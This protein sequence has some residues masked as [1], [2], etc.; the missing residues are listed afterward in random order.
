MAI[1]I[2]RR[3]FVAALG[4]VAVAWPLTARAQQ[5]GMPRIGVLNG[6]S[7]SEYGHLIAAFREALRENGYVENQNIEIEYRWADGQYDKLPALAADLIANKVT[8]IFATGGIASA[9]AAKSV[10]ATIPIV[11]ANGSDPVKLGLVP[12]LNRPAGNATGIVFFALALE[13]KRVQLL[14]ELVPDV[15]TIGFLVNK[16]N[17]NADFQLSDVQA[18]VNSIGLKA[19]IFPAGSKN[20]ISLAF[21]TLVRQRIRALAILTDPV[22][23]SSLEQIAVLAKSHAVA[24]IASS[25]AFPTNG[26]LINYGPNVADAY[27]QAAGYVARIL[28][29]ASPADLP[30]Q[31]STKFE[32]VINITTAKALGLDVPPSLIAIAD[33]VIE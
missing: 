4:G 32:L 11:F 19:E 28:K 33:E 6:A 3:Q 9:I 30:V 29:G 7:Q 5:P 10:T 15:D 12:S 16:S 25:R 24:T 21:A 27:R 2:G 14:H 31:Q 23:Q 18:A 17:L 22:F 1:N 26:G 20:E 13:A 8:L